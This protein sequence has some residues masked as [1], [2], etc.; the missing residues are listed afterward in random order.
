MLNYLR[1]DKSN[2]GIN[3]TSFRTRS[4]LLGDIVYSAAVPVGA[5]S[6]PYADTGVAGSPNPGY[7]AF[8]AAQG[9]GARRWSTWAATTGCCMRS[10]T[11]AANGGKEAWAYIPKAMF[12]GGDPNDTAHTPRAAFQ[13]GALAFRRGG[14]PLYSH[15]FYVNAT[16]R[17]W[18]IDFANTNTST[19]PAT[20]NDWRTILVG[21]LG[22]GGRAVYAL[23]VTTPI[24]PP[25]PV[26]SADTEATAAGEGAVGI[27]RSEPRL[28]L[29][30]ADAGQDVRLR[31]GRAGRVGLQQSRRQG[32]PLCP[33]SERADARRASC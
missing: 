15:K 9:A 32:L 6:A 29:R 21:G 18:D 11:R 8:K 28:R 2:E 10:S 13:L 30:R 14:I 17:V 25:P 22:A 4:H 3:T 26:V 12:S 31:L 5:P 23:D 16:P 20:G 19:P 7:N 24:A 1:G 33:Q 27:H